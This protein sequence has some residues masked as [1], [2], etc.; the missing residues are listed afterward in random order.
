MIQNRIPAG[1]V[2]IF[3]AFCVKDDLREKLYEFINT[4]EVRHD[5]SKYKMVRFEKDRF[6]LLYT[7][8]YYCLSKQDQLLLYCI[9]YH[10]HTILYKKESI[11]LHRHGNLQHFR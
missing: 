11:L 4:K 1:I 10:L 9:K 6:C 3:A 8:N 7:S 2:N 5:L